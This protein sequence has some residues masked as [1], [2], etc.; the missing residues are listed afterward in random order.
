MVTVAGI[1]VALALPSRPPWG[2]LSAVL[3][4]LLLAVAAAIK[5]V[6]LPIAVIGLI[7][8]LLVDRRRCAIATVAAALGGLA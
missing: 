6:T 3:G 8:L 5:V 4:G 1:G 7:A 2:V